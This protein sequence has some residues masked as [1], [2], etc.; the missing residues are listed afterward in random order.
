VLSVSKG[1]STGSTPRS[2]RSRP[3]SCSRSGTSRSTKR[4]RNDIV[5]NKSTSESCGHRVPA[6]VLRSGD[7]VV[8][9]LR[10]RALC[11]SRRDLGAPL[12]PARPGRLRARR[13]SI[14]GHFRQP[15]AGVTSAAV[16]EILFLR[17]KSCHWQGGHL[18]CSA[19][20]GSRSRWARTTTTSISVLGGR[21]SAIR[22]PRTEALL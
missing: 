13:A 7:G 16:R 22:R 21:K 2:S 11:S 15:E 20:A 17:Q 12:F 9:D 1:W 14:Q 5:Q 6:R 10:H 4:G 18:G 3:G 19:W 8:T